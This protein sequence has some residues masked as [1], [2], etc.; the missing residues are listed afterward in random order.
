MFIYAKPL[1]LASYAHV[2]RLTANG[3]NDRPNF[4]LTRRPGFLQQP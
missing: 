1:S 4:K 2:N 3:N